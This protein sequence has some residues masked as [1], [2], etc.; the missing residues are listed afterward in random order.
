M[1]LVLLLALLTASECDSTEVKG[2]AGQTTSLPCKYDRKYY[3]ALSVCWGRGEIPLFRCGDQLIS[4]DGDRVETRASSRYELLGR[5]E[6]GDVSLT[7]LHLTE[8]DA[9]RYG[10]RVAI[11]G[12]FNDEKHHVDLTVVT[13]PQIHTSTA[14]PTAAA[15]TEGHMTSTKSL[16]TSF[17]SVTSSREKQEGGL[18]T[19][20]LFYVL[21]GLIFLLIVSGLLII[22]EFR[23]KS[24]HTASTTRRRFTNS[25]CRRTEATLQNPSE[26]SADR[27][28]DQVQLHF[29][30]SAASH[31]TVRRG[32]HLPHQRQ[33]SHIQE[34][35]LSSQAPPTYLPRLEVGRQKQL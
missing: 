11:P 2:Q 28:L 25:L 13:A 35:P 18:L 14:Q 20:S 34:L 6:D 19:D 27:Q 7:I 23:I 30:D 32:Q 3:G 29:I 4:T 1:K 8:G 5:L 33:G 17:C 22:S 26:T 9:G 24:I 31:W 21:Q 15:Q 10:C 16:L 12:W